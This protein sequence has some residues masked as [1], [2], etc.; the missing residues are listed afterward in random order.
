MTA[1]VEV[2]GWAGALEKLV[3]GLAS[4]FCRDAGVRR[5]LSYLRGLLAP[6]ERKNGW[7]LAEAAGGVSP[8]AMQGF[9][10]PTRWGA[11]AGGDGL[12]GHVVENPGGEEAGRGPPW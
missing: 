9:L 7:Q 2:D 5:A 12:P 4:R 8:A 6:M 1:L 10:N 11:E 3:V